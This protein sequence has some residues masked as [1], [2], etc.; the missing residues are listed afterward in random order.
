MRTGVAVLFVAPPRAHGARH[1]AG[2]MAKL[3][4]TAVVQVRWKQHTTATPPCLIS[5]WAEV[6]ALAQVVTVLSPCARASSGTP[7]DGTGQPTWYH[8]GYFQA[9]D[10]PSQLTRRCRICDRRCHTR[11][12][13]GRVG[14]VPTVVSGGELPIRN[15]VE[16][17]RGEGG[18]G[19]GC[20]R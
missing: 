10:V 9:G 13:G 12:G 1:S 2:F 20:V 5:L 11:L 17:E 15:M 7:G 3:V 14:D 18:G 16:R 6:D 19:S 4:G 8:H